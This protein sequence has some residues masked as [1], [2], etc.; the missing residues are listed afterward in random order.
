MDQQHR[1]NLPSSLL[2]DPA[3]LISTRTPARMQGKIQVLVIGDSASGFLGKAI[4]AELVKRHSTELDT[5]VAYHGKNGPPPASPA[6]GYTVVDAN[7]TEFGEE[8]LAE[9]MQRFD[10]V[11]IVTPGLLEKEQ[12]VCNILKAAKAGGRVHF[13]GISSMLMAGTDTIFGKQLDA[14]ERHVASTGIDYSI[15]RLP[16]FIDNL[17]LYA[18]PIKVD[19]VFYDPRLPDKPHTPICVQDVGR[20]AA[21]VMLHC[22]QHKNTLYKLVAPPC[23]LNEI[24]EAFTK[25]AGKPVL[26]SH[27][28]YKATKQALLGSGFEEWQA[29]GVLEMYKMIDDEHPQACI[30]DN[31]DFARIT[32]EK[33]M[34]MPQWVDTY[35]AGFV[36]K[37]KS[38]DRHNESSSSQKKKSSSK[39]ITGLDCAASVTTNDS[40][41]SKDSKETS[42]SRRSKESS[43]SRRTKES[44][45]SRKK[46]KEK[47]SGDEPRRKH[48]SRRDAKSTEECSHVNEGECPP[49]EGV[50]EFPPVDEDGDCPQVDE[51]GDCPP[52]DEGGEC[53]P[54]AGEGAIHPPLEDEKLEAVAA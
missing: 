45:S 1:E 22:D 48:R 49:V 40:R 2:L 46:D 25:I 35:A 27:V 29:D 20:A 14:I 37:K 3:L 43:S 15:L 6:D 21:D 13:V 47:R 24:A 33:P 10:R 44:S 17:W 5:S 34:T 12:L 7:I 16:P 52:A 4:V 30:L 54:I 8:S 32:G 19:R 28:P 31:D 18:A 51:D 50:G 42:R 39:R 9:T 36:S 41:E 26:C 38:S 23:T 11:F 53:P